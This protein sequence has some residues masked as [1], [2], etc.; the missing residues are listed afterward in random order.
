MTFTNKAANEMRERLEKLIGKEKTTQ[1]KLGT[2]HALCALFLRKYG[3]VVGLGANFTICDADE[4]YR[5]LV[6][7]ICHNL[8][9][10]VIQQE[11]HIGAAQE[12]QGFP[13]RQGYHTQGRNRSL[14]DFQSE[15]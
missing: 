11:D 13:R 9:A 5:L 6:H 4:R 7:L 8:T 3:Q 2:F 14:H 12:T 1:V 15:I 10:N